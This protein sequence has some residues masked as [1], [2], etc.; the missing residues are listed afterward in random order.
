MP[1]ELYLKDTMFATGSIVV[2]EDKFAVKI[3]EILTNDP[4]DK[5]QTK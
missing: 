5:P 3:K 4:S 2:L 1:A